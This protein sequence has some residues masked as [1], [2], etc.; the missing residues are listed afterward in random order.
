MTPEQLRLVRESYASLGDGAPAMAKEFYRRLFDADPS[1]QELFGHGPEIM[2]E[3]FAAELRAIVELAASFNELAPHVRD[4]A[5][6]HVR[7][8]VQT[9]HYHSVGDALIG[10]L[11]VHL[12]PAWDAELEAAWRRAYS[13]VSEMMMDA[14]AGATATAR[15]SRQ[16]PGRADPGEPTG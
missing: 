7:Y 12:G 13:L 6:R 11:G 1:A 10:A 8:G 3:K 5:L 9:R 4:L 14:A 2:A 15:P 16:S